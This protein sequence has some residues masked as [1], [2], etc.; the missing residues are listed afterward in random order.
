MVDLGHCVTKLNDVIRVGGNMSCRSSKSLLTC[1]LC[2]WSPLFDLSV[3][4]VK[5]LAS[6][7]T[8]LRN[9]NICGFECNTILSLPG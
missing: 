1:S 5:M 4:D 7:L 8:H 2:H 3:D 9:L 6:T